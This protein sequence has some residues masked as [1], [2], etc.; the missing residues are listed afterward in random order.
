MIVEQNNNPLTLYEFKPC[1]HLIFFT[2]LSSLL[3]Y[4]ENYENLDHTLK[5]EFKILNF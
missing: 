1:L 3:F 2:N 4:K 5:P